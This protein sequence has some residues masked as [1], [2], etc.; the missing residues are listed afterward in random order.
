MS[1]EIEKL[2]EGLLPGDVSWRA[3]RL[4]EDDEVSFRF[5]EEAA[6]VEGAIAKR[7]IEHARGRHLAHALLDRLGASDGPLLTSSDRAP[8]WPE[9]FTGSISHTQGLCAA[10]VVEAAKLTSLGLDVEV[11]APLKEKLWPSIL[12]VSERALL[13]GIGA[14]GALLSKVYFSAK[15]AVYKAVSKEAGR[16]LEF[17]EVELMVSLARGSF[18][19]RFVD[20]GLA[21]RLPHVVGR[22][23]VRRDFIATAAW[24]QGAEAG[25]A[26]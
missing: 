12:T 6:A 5:S 13:S 10:A 3:E 26:R 24:P 1:A 19:A 4:G 23:R 7:Q 20:P 8:L 11:T 18:E 21:A 14:R 2:F 16:V 9:G 22:W 17:Q 25:R 15:E